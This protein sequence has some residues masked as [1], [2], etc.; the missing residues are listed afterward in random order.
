MT[1]SGAAWASRRPALEQARGAEFPSLARRLFGNVRLE[2][3][4]EMPPESRLVS[5]RIGPCR[6]SRLSAGRHVVH[7]ERVLAGDAPDMIKLIIQTEGLSALHQAG[8]ELPVGPNTAV[9]YDPANPY[10]LVNPE[11]V[12][13]LMLQVPRQAFT[14]VE[15]AR[16]RRPLVA[17]MQPGG[18]QRVLF[19]VMRS[20]MG[21]IGAM[22]EVA[23]DQLGQTM[24]DLVR[25][26]VVSQPGQEERPHSLDLLLARMKDYIAGQLTRPDLD[27]ADIARRMGCSLRYVYRA[28]EL[29]GV[30]PA[31]Y[32]WSE[33]LRKAAD[34]LRARPLKP[35]GIADVAF[36]LG[37]SSSA[38][39]SRAFRN[40]YRQSPREW[41]RAEG[42]N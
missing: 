24:L 13:L 3:A 40:R 20:A 21:E 9:L 32:I 8:R 11:A 22:D 23:R 16:L 38:H 1:G 25:G 18:L 42:L 2:F 37:F 7:G 33:R 14:S 39:F 17:T 35:G 41:A 27:A 15:L 36:G 12:D 26:L 4:E 6:L 28:F 30:T 19:S 34:E 5:A 29:T 10:V 31:E